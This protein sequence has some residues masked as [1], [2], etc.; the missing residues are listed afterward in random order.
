MHEHI[1]ALDA[2][3]A[4]CILIL[5][6]ARLGHEREQVPIRLKYTLF[7]RSLWLSRFAVQA[8][9]GKIGEV[10]GYFIAISKADTQYIQIGVFAVKQMVLDGLFAFIGGDGWPIAQ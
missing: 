5:R 10:V 6:V 1:G 2:R 3:S 4:K 7:L 9:G 8:I